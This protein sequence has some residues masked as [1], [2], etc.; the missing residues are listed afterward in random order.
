MKEEDTREVS[1]P[2]LLSGLWGHLNRRRQW[3]TVAVT[4]LMVGSAFAE[5]VSLGTV[6][7]FIAVLVEPER[8][9]SFGPIA[10]IADWVGIT[11]ADD[12]LLPLAGV[13][14][15]VALAAASLRLL[16]LWATNRWAVATGAELASKAFERTLYQ[17]YEVHVRRHS[18]EVTSGVIQK[19]ESV[20]YGLLIPLQT[21]VGA[22]L[23]LLSVTVALLMID[24]QIAIV[25]LLVVCGSYSV[26]TLVVRGRLLRNGRQIATGQVR[27]LKI[28]QDSIGGIREVL[29]NRH[30][31]VFLEEFRDSD[32]RLRRAQASNTV[33]QMSPRLMMEGIAMVLIVLLVLIVETRDGG[34]IGHLP[35]IAA[36]VVAGQRMFPASQQCY[37]AA[38]IITAFRPSLSEALTILDQPISQVEKFEVRDP[39][40]FTSVLGCS[41]LSFRYADNEPWV[42]NDIDLQISKGST[43]G[44]AGET[45]SGKSTL[46]DLMMGLLHPSIGSFTVDGVPLEG[47]V[48]GAW[49]QSIAHVPQDVFLVDSSIAENIAFGVPKD[50]ID[51][52]RVRG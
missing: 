49:R 25:G 4:L 23:T 18:S 24:S 52:E 1:F 30:Q 12:L 32:G 22:A 14:V 27:V 11:S 31:E 38:G 47:A 15:V 36:F 21:F 17:P 29:V 35:E 33:I 16:V 50:L 51:F 26:T 42:L 39:F 5:V 13:F 9:M 6:L 20:V 37:G 45:G 41:G 48:I 28:I 44:L 2:R 7:P 8:A 46:L 40:P 3:Q 43:V 10:S 34:L 19:V